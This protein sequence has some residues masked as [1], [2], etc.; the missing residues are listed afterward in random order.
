MT[1]SR[2]LLLTLKERTPVDSFQN[3]RNEADV[4]VKLVEAIST[5]DDM[6]RTSISIL[7]TTHYQK[8]LIT[9]KIAERDI[10][11]YHFPCNYFDKNVY[12]VIYLWK[13]NLRFP[14]D[15]RDSRVYRIIEFMKGSCEI[16]IFSFTLQQEDHRTQT[17]WTIVAFELPQLLA[18]I[19]ARK[20]LYMVGPF[21]SFVNGNAY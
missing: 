11:I 18:N 1:H 8:N 2:D 20:C 17:D 15:D 7:T 3:E 16:V 10:Y 13:K 5:H 14:N 12:N 21:S 19:R 4:V 9:E 6:K